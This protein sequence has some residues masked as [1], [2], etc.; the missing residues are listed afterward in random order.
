MNVFLRWMCIAEDSASPLPRLSSTLSLHTSRRQSLGLP[1]DKTVRFV[2]FCDIVEM[3]EKL[4]EEGGKGAVGGRWSR[5][6]RGFRR[7]SAQLWHDL[8]DPS[9]MRFPWPT[10][11]PLE[12]HE[13]VGAER[14]DSSSHRYHMPF[15]WM[16]MAVP[17]T[18]AWGLMVCMIEMAFAFVCFFCVI[19]HYLLF[20]P[21]CEQFGRPLLI[22]F[23]TAV[24]YS[25][26]YSF[27]VLFVIAVVER[28]ARLLRVQLFFQYA[29]CVFLLLDA[30]F[31]LA[32]DLGGYNEEG[33]YCEKNP[34]LIRF[35]A[36]VSLVFLFVQLFLR[37]ATVQVFN[38]MWDTRKFRK[39]LHNSKWRYRK[40]VY[41]SYC[42]IMQED[43]KRLQLKNKETN[44]ITR[45]RN[46]QEEI[47]KKIQMKQNVTNILISPDE[48][49]SASPVGS[50]STLSSSR[51]PPQYLVAPLGKR[52]PEKSLPRKAKKIRD[53]DGAPRMPPKRRPRPALRK[54]GVRIQ[55]EVDHETV[56]LLLNKNRQNGPLP[57]KIEEDNEASDSAAIEI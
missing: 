22:F 3:K 42:S 47:L 41:F 24:Q 2:C 11:T 16:T 30:S 54:G 1:S 14:F 10:N 12:V 43:M 53:E 40:R 29:T 26:F 18:P 13:L 8:S 15:F 52:K 37:I 21:K 23:L 6:V 36:V 46:E 57:L 35:V 55:L 56:R 25:V 27:K 33:I 28:R 45:I 51:D 17:A 50:V 38:F 19:L 4:L 7:D 9:Q 5:F 34:M 39:A 49:T 44:V 32:S 48:S 31:A 20:L